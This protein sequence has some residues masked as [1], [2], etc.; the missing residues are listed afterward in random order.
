MWGRPPSAVRSSKARLFLIGQLEHSQSSLSTHVT[1]GMQLIT[2]LEHF[3]GYYGLY[4]GHS[5]VGHSRQPG[6][7]SRRMMFFVWL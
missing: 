1:L 4:F 5:S 3:A 2:A 7:D 6:I